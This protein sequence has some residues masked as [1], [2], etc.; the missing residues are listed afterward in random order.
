LITLATLLRERRRRRLEA[1]G[2]PFDEE[3]T[4]RVHTGR[5]MTVAETLRF[6]RTRQ[7]AAKQK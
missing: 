7:L 4:P 5:R 6:S 3:P 2:Q 1:T